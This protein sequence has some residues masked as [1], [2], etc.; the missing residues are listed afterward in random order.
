MSIPSWNLPKD[1]PNY[2]AY[3]GVEK[4]PGK[5]ISLDID[6]GHTPIG[7][8]GGLTQNQIP[9]FSQLGSTLPKTPGVG[10]GGT[11]TVNG[12]QTWYGRPM[13]TGDYL[14]LMQQNAS[15]GGGGI[16]GVQSTPFGHTAGGEN[17]RNDPRTQAAAQASA[18][19]A[20][21]AN[22]D[23]LAKQQQEEA[24]RR[25]MDIFRWMI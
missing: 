12:K 17:V 4:L 9:G 5:S 22:F 13:Q 2:I 25:T 16:M 20:T 23:R 8:T 21:Q 18:Y 24:Y 15:T 14:N 7:Q 1:D 6:G 11:S 3:T 10:A 19:A